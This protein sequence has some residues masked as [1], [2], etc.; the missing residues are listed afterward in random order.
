MAAGPRRCKGPAWASGS[1]R[2]CWSGSPS[3]TRKSVMTEPRVETQQASDGY[4]IHVAVWPAE[5]PLKGHVVIL[6]GVQSHS[7]WYHGLG[8]TLAG[9]GYDAYF[10]DRRGSGANRQDRGHTPSARRLIDDIAELLRSIRAR[11]E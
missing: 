4:P 5:G 1:T 10:P 3:A 7:G 2:R 11:R 8:R 6:H 9:A